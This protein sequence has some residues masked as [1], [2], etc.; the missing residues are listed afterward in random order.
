MK[1]IAENWKHFEQVDIAPAAGLEQR[2]EMRRAFYAGA[3]SMLM[4]CAK[5]IDSP[6][7]PRALI[8]LNNEMKRYIDDTRR[9]LTHKDPDGHGH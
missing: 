1:T 5:A 3:S 9:G 4:L 6:N 7:P 8:E 2:H